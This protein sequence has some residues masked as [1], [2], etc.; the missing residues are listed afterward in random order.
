MEDVKDTDKD[1]GREERNAGHIE[2]TKK[3]NLKVVSF[4]RHIQIDMFL[5]F[6]V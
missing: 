3:T 4:T 5:V 6:I 1:R 2:D